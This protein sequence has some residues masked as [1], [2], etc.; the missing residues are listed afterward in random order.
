MAAPAVP[1]D[2]ADLYAAVQAVGM[3]LCPALGI[4][5]P[6]GK[7]SM[8]M[9]TVWADPATS[10]SKR[11][12]APTSLII[13][14]FAPVADIRQSLTPQ[15]ITGG[16]IGA[17]LLYVIDLGRGK[18]RLGGSILAQVFGQTSQAPADVDSPADLKAFWNAIQ[19]LGRE[20]KILAYHDR[21][22]GGLLAAAAEMA[23][24]GNT[25]VTLILPQG[26]DPFACLF[27]EELGA[28]IQVKA[29]EAHYVQNVLREH[30]LLDCVTTHG[31]P[32]QNSVVRVLST[33]GQE[34]FSESIFTLRS[35]WSDVTRR[36]AGLRDNPACAEQEHALRID[37]S[38]PGLSPK[39][40]FDFSPATIGH[41]SL[42]IGHSGA[43]PSV[44]IL[45]EQGVNGEVEMA[46]AFTRAGFKA[47]DVHMTDILSG[48]VSLRDF[49]GLAAC[50]G[51]SYGDVLGAGE[52]W[53]KSI[54]FNPRA[55][56]EFAAFFAREDTFALGV[57]NGCQMMSNLHS[58]IPGAAHWPRFVQNQSER[59]E[60]RV[61]S[62]LIEKSPS[63]LFAGMEGSVLPVAIAHGE[64][65]TEFASPEAAVACN[66]SGLVAARFVDNHHRPT[67]HYPLNPNGSPFG[68]TAL[69]TTTGR[70]TIL[71]PHPERVFRVVQQS[72]APPAW[73]DRDAAPWLRL[74]QN[75][76]AWVG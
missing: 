44:A 14:A 75:A 62:L 69:T 12:T 18:D 46:A 59:F 22:D 21:S 17:T 23:F 7:D 35:V 41:W 55:H 19:R 43:K 45:R 51:F 70:V 50:G 10:A 63:V 36:M 53:A 52:G 32:N 5:I 6:V 3:E 31:T 58:I 33:S 2:G 74:F 37:P 39:V 27:S 38:N 42:D 71:M 40:T 20:G 1:G 11:V 30:N 25:G 61:A 60:A 24:A 65:F 47:V 13:S 28:I 4:T 16:G 66:A 48:R 76:R 29:S 9:S 68:I 67:E 56:D 54:L 73:R 34:I 72:W 57:C 64:G 49:R 15:L 26:V 8:S